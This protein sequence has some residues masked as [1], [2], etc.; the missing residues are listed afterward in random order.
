M[1]GVGYFVSIVS[2]F[3]LGLVAWP[4]PGEPRWKLLA[5]LLGMGAS[6]VGMGLRWLA[7]RKQE[8]ELHDVERQVGAR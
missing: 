3:L 8:E 1:R 7:S 6:I 5:L 4:G 2:V